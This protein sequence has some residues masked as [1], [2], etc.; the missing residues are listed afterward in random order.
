MKKALQFIVF[1]F[2]ALIFLSGNAVQAAHAS[3]D[4]IRVAALLDLSGHYSQ[5]GLETKQAMELGISET[6]NIDV[7]FFDT[8]GDLKTAEQRL[9][10]VIKQGGYTVV[11]TLA[12]WISNGLAAKIKSN[13]LLQ[14]AVGSAVFDYADQKNCVR[15]TGDVGREIQYL[16][17]YL[18]RYNKVAVMYFNNDYGLSWN[19]ALRSAL[20]NKLVKSVAY[21][22]TDVDFTHPLNEIKAVHPDALAL[23]STREAVQIAKQASRIRMQTGLFG[24]RPTL[25]TPLLAEPTAGGLMFSYPD[26]NETLP[27]FASFKNK[28]GYRMSAF[29]AEGYDLIRSL[30]QF[31]SHDRNNKV[32]FANYQN[33]TYDGALGHIT[34]NENAQADY[35]YTICVIQNGTWGKMK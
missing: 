21:T 2:A 26:L 30:D 17:N 7:R 20:G 15:F 23:I 12:S 1:S 25:T 19:N 8:K 5:F 16:T 10:E 6:Q 33:R 28:Y 13:G 4:P 29:G 11:V 18:Q 34:F 35:D 32:L 24:T 9:N 31:Y 22:D 27:V 14:M 3:G